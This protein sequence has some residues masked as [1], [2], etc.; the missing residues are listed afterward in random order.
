MNR[1]FEL[2]IRNMK[3]TNDRLKEIVKELHQMNQI[4]AQQIS[5]REDDMK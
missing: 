4:L 3:E 5:K 1:E 2:I